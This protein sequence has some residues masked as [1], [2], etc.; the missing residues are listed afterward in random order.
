M[1]GGGRHGNKGYFVQPT[2]FADVEDHMRVAR[3]EVKSCV[4]S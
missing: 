3:E 2:V 4:I 1:C